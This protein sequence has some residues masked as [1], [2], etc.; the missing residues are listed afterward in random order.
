MYEGFQSFECIHTAVKRSD[1]RCQNNTFGVI[2]VVS[3]IGGRVL[4]G[5]GTYWDGVEDGGGEG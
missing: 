4:R 5:E 3:G 2:T 1:K